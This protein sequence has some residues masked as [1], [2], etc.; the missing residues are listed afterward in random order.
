MSSTEMESLLSRIA[1]AKSIEQLSN[2][3][4]EIEDKLRADNAPTAQFEACRH[5]ANQRM[6]SLGLATFS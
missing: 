6:R 1:A 2:A 4:R 5:A 3:V